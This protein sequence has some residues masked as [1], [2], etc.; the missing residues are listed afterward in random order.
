MRMRCA[1]RDCPSD[2]VD[3]IVAHLKVLG[4]SQSLPGEVTNKNVE[5]SCG[6]WLMNATICVL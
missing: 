4:G 2:T 3:A 5:R 1:E 6:V